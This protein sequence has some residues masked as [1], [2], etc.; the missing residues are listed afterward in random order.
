MLL[1]VLVISSVGLV[2]DLKQRVLGAI[3]AD[4]RGH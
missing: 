4:F 1:L 2:P 3:I